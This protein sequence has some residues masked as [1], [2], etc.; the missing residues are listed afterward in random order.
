M[1]LLLDTH[2]MLALPDDEVYKFGKRV[3]TLLRDADALHV[4]VVSLWEMAIKHR[5]GKLSFVG[6]A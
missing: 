5:L 4:S 6:A 2:I 3:L 1:R